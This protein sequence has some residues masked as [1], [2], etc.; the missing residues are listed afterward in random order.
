[1][2]YVLDDWLQT[3]TMAAELR[4]PQSTSPSERKDYVEHLMKVLGLSKV[5][6]RQLLLSSAL[7]K[8]QALTNAPTKFHAKSCLFPAETV[9]CCACTVNKSALTLSFYMITCFKSQQPHLHAFVGGKH[10]RG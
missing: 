7:H 1:M 5:C 6:F 4:L 8:A 9:H 10:R 3:L 2:S